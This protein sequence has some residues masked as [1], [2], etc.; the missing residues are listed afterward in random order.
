M[1][2]VVNAVDVLIT[3]GVDELDLSKIFETDDKTGLDPSP[4][5]LL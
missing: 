5:E 4:H 2:L 3:D 1:V